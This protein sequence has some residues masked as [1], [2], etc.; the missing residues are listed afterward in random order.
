MLQDNPLVIFIEFLNLCLNVHST[1]DNLIEKLQLFRKRMR[2]LSGNSIIS[3][4]DPECTFLSNKVWIQKACLLLIAHTLQYN[5]SSLCDQIR[6]LRCLIDAGVFE[7]LTH[8]TVRFFNILQILNVLY[9][10]KC[11][12]SLDLS[13]ICNDAD[14]YCKFIKGCVENLVDIKKYKV[15]LKVTEIEKLSPDSAVI[16]EL[17]NCI[18]DTTDIAHWEK[19][20]ET[21]KMY[22]VDPQN[23]VGFFKE[24]ADKV[25]HMHIRHELLK[26][27]YAWAIENDLSEKNSL[28]QQMWLSFVYMKD[29]HKKEFTPDMNDRKCYREMKLQL[30]SIPQKTEEFQE[31]LIIKVKDSINFLLHHDCFWDALVLEKI[32]NCK[33]Q[34]LEILK[35]CCSI[36]E[37][38]LLP[39]ELDIE[40]KILISRASA[41]RNQS[42]KHSFMKSKRQSSLS[43]SSG[44]LQNNLFDSL[45]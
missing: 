15:A 12:I 8:D 25:D 33:N 21:F 28:L 43:I 45:V 3:D 18:R 42:K 27:A 30:A 31:G 32:F 10:H 24:F 26:Y 17:K 29:D 44:K 2:R 40:Q 11:D 22:K 37:G 13:V 39:E 41:Y 34:N 7:M 9:E 35:V 14:D 23:A 20:N 1:N 5:I 4:V 16:E 38:M 6:F 19:C 36:A